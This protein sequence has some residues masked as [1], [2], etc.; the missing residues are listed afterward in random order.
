[1][2]GLERRIDALEAHTPDR[3]VAR[4][5]VEFGVTADWVWNLVHRMFIDAHPG[6]SPE[7]QD[8]R[9]AALHQLDAEGLALEI[10]RLLPLAS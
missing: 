8:A 10:D 6:E 9:I 3:I 4:L 2:S 5:A 7:A 1:M